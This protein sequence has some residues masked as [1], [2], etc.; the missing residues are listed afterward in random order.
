[1]AA[2]RDEKQKLSMLMPTYIRV[3][4]MNPNLPPR[5]SEQLVTGRRLALLPLDR[6]ALAPLW[7]SRA[8]WSHS[9]RPDSAQC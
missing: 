5:Q 8:A 6:P 7:S 4:I 3:M 2:C 9:A 1:M